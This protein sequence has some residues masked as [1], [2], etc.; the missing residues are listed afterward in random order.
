MSWKKRR[1]KT[2]TARH[3]DMIEALFYPSWDLPAL[4]FFHQEF[5]GLAQL[6]PLIGGPTRI[7]E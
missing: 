4:H 1:E 6:P 5:L 2:M 3:F 7:F